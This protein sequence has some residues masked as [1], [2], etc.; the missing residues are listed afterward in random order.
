LWAHARQQQHFFL[1]FFLSFFCACVTLLAC[2]HWKKH[3]Y[4][5]RIVTS[6]IYLSEKRSESKLS[7][8]LP[9]YYTILDIPQDMGQN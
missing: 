2:S 9:A 4:A 7:I 3:C 8:V 5:L 6:W 1:L